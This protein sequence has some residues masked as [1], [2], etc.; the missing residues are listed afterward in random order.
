MLWRKLSAKENL[1]PANSTIGD[2]IA[3]MNTAKAK[4]GVLVSDQLKLLGTF[5]D[6]DL[7]RALAHGANLDDLTSG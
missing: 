6:G 1:I 3:C 2:A 5:T 4:I 7:R